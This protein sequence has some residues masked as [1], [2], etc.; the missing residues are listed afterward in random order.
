ML[1]DARRNYDIA[2]ALRLYLKE[3]F[4]NF[5]EYTLLPVGRSLATC[6]EAL[7]H[8]GA[9]IKFLP[10]SGLRGHED[11]FGKVAPQE[12]SAYKKYLSFMNL[13]KEQIRNN[14]T[15]KYIIMDYTSTGR[16]LK[17][18]YDFFTREE[19]LSNAPNIEMLS[20]EDSLEFKYN[21]MLS[22][23]L[24]KRYSSISQLNIGEFEN[25]F[26]AADPYKYDYQNYINSPTHIRTKLFRLRMFELLD[27]NN[28]L[29][30]LL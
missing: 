29:K 4:G 17:K 19:L 2:C 23:E 6:C 9:D 13:S 3:H 15:H 25:V 12:V 8:M 16:S 7:S 18:A 22:N 5:K 11:S 28:E 1:K 20:T 26:K 21:G 14:P 30:S 24:L 27:K 10:L